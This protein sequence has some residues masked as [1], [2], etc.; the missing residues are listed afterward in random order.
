MS[1]DDVHPH[2]VFAQRLAAL[3]DQVER[4]GQPGL[5]ADLYELAASLTPRGDA[6]RQRA[7]ALRL[8]ASSTEDPDREHK[9]RNL[10][11]SHAVGMARIL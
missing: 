1:T 11:A 4:G 3:A 9:R 5:A 7:T 6:Y 10:E 8:V 2:P